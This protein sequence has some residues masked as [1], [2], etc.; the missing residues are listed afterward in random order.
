[1]QPERK[2]PDDL[3]VA[4]LQ[5]TLKCK[6]AAPKAAC[7]GLAEFSAG[8]AWNLDT[9]R[10]Q[11]ARW[12]GQAWV[13]DKGVARSGY[14][15]F[16]LKKVPTNEVAPGD[17]PVKV[18][19]RELDPTLGPENTH[20]PKLLRLLQHD[21]AIPK[22]N[23]TAEHV[24]TYAPA[25]WDLATHTSASS[26]FVPSGEGIWVREGGS[27]NLLVVHLVAAATGAVPGDGVYANLYPVSW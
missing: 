25:S 17:L 3:D 10:G 18:A 1:M 15:F 14:Y 9:V 12:F 11:D 13:L 5:E 16:V 24:K 22:Q 26:T 20:A 23:R 27:R 2:R 19:L 7:L 6:G 8:R 21:D 4:K